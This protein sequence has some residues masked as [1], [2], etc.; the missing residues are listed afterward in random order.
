MKMIRD[1]PN[2]TF[3]QCV[4]YSKMQ[5]RIGRT[6]HRVSTHI[7]MFCT[8]RA[9]G[10]STEVPISQT[11]LGGQPGEDDRLCTNCKNKVYKY[12]MPNENRRLAIKRHRARLIKRL[13]PQLPEKLHDII[14]EY[15]YTKATN[16]LHVMQTGWDTT[17]ACRWRVKKFYTK[18]EQQ[19]IKDEQDSRDWFIYMESHGRS[20]TI[21]SLAW[22]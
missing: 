22:G 17:L 13:M 4:P 6:A 10:C 18:E 14:L 15:Q 8:K 19:L 16:Q 9:R 3:E 20:L 5:G 7:N 12:G 11:P 2:L 1:L 21:S